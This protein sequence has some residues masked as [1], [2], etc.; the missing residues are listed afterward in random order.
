MLSGRL[1]AATVLEVILL[2]PASVVLLPLLVFGALGSAFAL[3][4][5]LVQ[6]NLTPVQRLGAALLPLTT[7]LWVLAASV[8]MAAAWLAALAPHIAATRGWRVVLAAALMAGILAAVVWLYVMG[9][10]RER[11]DAQTW[12][13]WIAMLG[14]PLVVA[15][16]RL[17][18]LTRSG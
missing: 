10:S 7:L 12:A 2:L 18:V 5:L 13:L 1:R 11:Y 16:R 17:V 9:T 14:G 3:P 15:V 4:V 8:G 6:T